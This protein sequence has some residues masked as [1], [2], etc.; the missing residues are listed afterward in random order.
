MHRNIRHS[1]ASALAVLALAVAAIT[2]SAQPITWNPP[3]PTARVVN[4]SP[5]AVTINLRTG[6]G[7]VIPPF[8]VNPC[9]VATVPA[10]PVPAGTLIGGIFTQAGTFVPLVS[11]GP[12]IAPFLTPCPFPASVL[13]SDGWIRG[14]ILPP[15]GCCVDLYFYS[16]ADPA[17][18][19][20]I[21]VVPGTAPCTP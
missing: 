13:P 19:C 17:F 21:F 18:P 16:A 10:V 12:A 2:A 7:G 6:P 11:P 4:F 3:C 1:I 8:T 9:A 5:C 20:T 14:V 15:T